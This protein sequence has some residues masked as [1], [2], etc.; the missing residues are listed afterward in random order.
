MAFTC[1][2]GAQGRFRGLRVAKKDGS[3]VDGKQKAYGLL[4]LDEQDMITAMDGS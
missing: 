4:G 3:W 2:V 1:T